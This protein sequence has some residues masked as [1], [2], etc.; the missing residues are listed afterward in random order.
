MLPKNTCQVDID[1]LL[2]LH[3]S[4]MDDSALTRNGD[5]TKL[6]ALGSRRVELVETGRKVLGDKLALLSPHRLQE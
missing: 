4:I 5:T 2:L 3:K 6:V 1:T